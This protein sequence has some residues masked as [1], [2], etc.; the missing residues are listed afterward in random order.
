MTGTTTAGLPKFTME[1]E[2]TT[3]EHLGLKLYS[4]LPPV[5]AELVSNAWDADATRVEITFPTGS[6]TSA[7]EVVVR[8][9]GSGMEATAIQEEY[10][11]IGRNRRREKGTD[12]SQGGR[13][14]TGSKGLGK[15]SA[16][17]VASQLE[18]RT[19]ANG[20]AVCIS[21]DFAEMKGWPRGKPYEPK[22]VEK[23]SGT[24]GEDSG[25]EVRIRGLHRTR[26][27]EDSWIRQELAR[28]FTVIGDD[29]QVVVNSTAIKPSDRRLKGDCKKAWDVKELDGHGVVD[30]VNKWEV[31]GWIGV[32]AKAAQTDRGVDIF[33]RGKVVELDSMFRLSTTHKQFARAYV[34]GEVHAEFLD[35]EED[36]ISTA[37]NSVNW[38]SE[39][40]QRL[41]EWGEKALKDVFTRWV[42][43]QQ[44]EK[45]EQII[46]VGKFDEW[47]KTRTEREQRVARKLVRVI[48]DDPNVEPEATGPMLEVIKS[49]IEFTAFQELVDELEDSGGNVATLL[50]LFAEWRVFEA[51]ELL[52]LSDGRLEAMT[53][54]AG[55]IERGA[56]EVKQ[57]QPL[58]EENPWLIDT[59][60]GEAEGQT[61]YTTL[62]RRQF[63]ESKD[64]PEADRRIDILG[65]RISGEVTVVELKRPEKVLSSKDLAQIEDYVDWAR[66]KFVGTGPDSPRYVRGLLVVG[67]LSKDS[68]V[69]E[70]VVRLA[71]D[72]IRVETF[73]DLLERAQAVYGR[74]E[75]RYKDIAPEYTREARRKAKASRTKRPAEDG[76]LKLVR[77]K[78]KGRRK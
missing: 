77:R 27:I 18:V 51:R 37:R 11:R 6:L 2:P 69:R 76:G 31:T 45:E 46:K 38:E 30:S 7:S 39:P 43:L 56:L 48:V 71:G 67:H 14:V 22:V 60:W 55:F 61:T 40:G 59:A 75:K 5:I 57:M 29:F 52:R 8:D 68:G 17:G 26:A 78:T 62:L 47:L 25:T 1:F 54:L 23:R 4:S 58:F 70:K 50:R 33:A 20:F 24:T 49:N 28:R 9:Y 66:S 15:L 42:E 12:R 64:A 53:K 32:V 65:I 63:P 3:I 44:K 21:L 41:H 36:H 10:L 73:A 72:D 35:E 16:F 74:I 34:V 13:K 19:I